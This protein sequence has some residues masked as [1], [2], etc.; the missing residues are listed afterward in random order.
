MRGQGSK[1]A[2]GKPMQ[3]TRAVHVDLIGDGA[4][5]IASD[6]HGL[7]QVFDARTGEPVG[8][9]LKHESEVKISSLAAYTG[10]T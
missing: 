9:A 2:V 7:V 4:R 5:V 6:A 3:L 1:L 10:A 8:P